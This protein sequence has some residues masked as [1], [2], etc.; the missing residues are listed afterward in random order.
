MYFLLFLLFMFGASLGSFIGAQVWREERNIQSKRSVCDS[1]QSALPWYRLIPFFSSLYGFFSKS[2]KHCEIKLPIQYTM[3]ECIT[4]LFLALLSLY[5]I[6]NQYLS[7][8]FADAS[9]ICIQIVVSSLI[10]YILMRLAYE[11]YSSHAITAKV[12][13]FFLFIAVILSL[14]IFLTHYVYITYIISTTL[15][16][17]LFLVTFFSKERAMGLGDPLVLLSTFLFFGSINP[18]APITIFFYTIWT[19]AI[20]SISFMLYKFGRF[21][22]GV[23]VPFLP[24]L[25]IGILMLLITRFYLFELSAILETWHFLVG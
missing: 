25:I 2:C 19:A 16:L 17:P 18:S 7:F 23:K 12:V 3:L 22:R 4:G 10:T 15:I 21:E 11:D 13:Y 8:Y 6:D 5:I 1:C 9:L 14:L 24:F 20:I